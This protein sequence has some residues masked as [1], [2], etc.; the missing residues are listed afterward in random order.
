MKGFVANIFQIQTVLGFTVNKNLILE[1]CI[2]HSHTI[3]ARMF[4]PSKIF[5]P[6]THYAIKIMLHI[7][8]LSDLCYLSVKFFLFN[9][10]TLVLF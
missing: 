2:I 10:F 4:K 6:G 1:L 8:Q 5:S 7:S 9:I 3:I